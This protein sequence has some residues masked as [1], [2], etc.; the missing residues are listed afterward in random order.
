MDTVEQRVTKLKDRLNIQYRWLKSVS[1]RVARLESVS[2]KVGAAVPQA[3]HA[4][5][6][7]TGAASAGEKSAQIHRVVCG[8]PEHASDFSG[9]ALPGC[10]SSSAVAPEGE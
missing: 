6:S 9:A 3:Q 4:E 10:P 5:T 7:E 8:G 1:E 2:P